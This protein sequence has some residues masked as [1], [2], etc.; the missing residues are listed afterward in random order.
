MKVIKI[1][2]GDEVICD[3]CNKSDAIDS[4]GGFIDGS[5]AICP[6]CACKWKPRKNVI[7]NILLPF[8]EFILDYRRQMER[9]E[10][11]K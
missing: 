4:V 8:K 10:E 11:V 6:I 1:D 3:S 5:Y 9:P 7:I 2:A